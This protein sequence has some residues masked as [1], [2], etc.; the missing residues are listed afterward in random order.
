VFDPIFVRLLKT[1]LARGAQVLAARGATA[2]AVTYC[3]FALGLLG[4]GAIAGGIFWLAL[5][6]LALNRL[7]DGLDGALARVTAPTDFGAYLD[8]VLDFMIYTA[9]AGAF[10]VAN[11][12]NVIPAIVL[13]ISF[14]GTGASFLAF[15]V[16]A[17]QRGLVT[18]E[19]GEKSFFYV[20]GLTEGTETVVFFAIV[21]LWPRAFPFAAWVFAAMC[22]I[23]IAQR[24]ASAKA[25]FER[26]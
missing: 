2:N 21:L 14:M 10:A 9:V 18:A 20:G 7:A 23:T 1:P 19:R 24:V 26:G 15:A 5:P 22:W 11:A 4:A 25:T 16:I 3:G 8:I 13:V 6:L 12:D 17:A